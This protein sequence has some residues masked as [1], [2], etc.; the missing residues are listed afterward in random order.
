M[1]MRVDATRQQERSPQPMW[2]ARFSVVIVL[3]LIMG[4]GVRAHGR[5]PGHPLN[6]E[7]VEMSDP[8]GVGIVTGMTLRVA[9]YGTTDISP[10]Y[11]TFSSS[12]GL[13]PLEWRR[14]SGP[15]PLAPGS[16]GL[17]EIESSAETGIAVADDFVVRVGDARTHTVA[18]SAPV[19]A[20]LKAPL[21][22]ANPSFTWW[23]IDTGTG[24]PAPVGWTIVGITSPIGPHL[25]VADSMIAGRQALA[26][27]F[28]DGGRVSRWQGIRV[29]Q[30]IKGKEQV[31]ELLDHGFTV[32]VYPTFNYTPG[33]TVT[34][35]GQPGNALGIQTWTDGRL[36]WIV[37]SDEGA[38]WHIDPR[39]PSI[40]VV[41][42]HSPLNHWAYHRID[43]RAMYQRLHWAK[44]HD[45]VISLFATLRGGSAT[46]APAFGQ[47]SLGASGRS[48]GRT[49]VHLGVPGAH[50][51]AGQGAEWVDLR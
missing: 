15:M 26:F 38:G 42:L 49:G 43:L 33:F 48:D 22:I 51:W 19:R 30:Q 44:P 27:R 39:H 40:A 50:F 16:V 29:Y 34:S 18:A 25:R 23:V 36:L 5:G 32:S 47:I 4:F 24:Q 3:A 14:R 41:V 46:P 28:G 7:V 11:T 45:V 8:L 17:Y 35:K 12:N 2:V 10:V 20:N 1:P 31:A 6:V 9:N 21:A 13:L 37:F